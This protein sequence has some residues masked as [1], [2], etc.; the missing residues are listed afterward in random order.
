LVAAVRS[1]ALLTSADLYC[2]LSAL[3]ENLAVTGDSAVEFERLL[4]AGALD[5]VSHTLSRDEFLA[6]RQ[7]AYQH[8]AARYPRYFADPGQLAFGAFS[9]TRRKV[10]GTT[11]P[12]DSAL[13]LWSQDLHTQYRFEPTPLAVRRPVFEALRRREGQAITFAYFEPQLGDLARRPGAGHAIRRQISRA[14]TDDYLRMMDGDIVT[15]IRGL[16]IFDDLASRFPRYDLPVLGQIAYACGADTLVDVV[17]NSPDDMYPLYIARRQVPAARAAAAVRWLVDALYQL[18]LDSPPGRGADPQEWRSQANVRGRLRQQILG[19]TRVRGRSA[20]SAAGPAEIYGALEAAALSLAKGVAKAVPGVAPLLERTRG[21]LTPMNADVVLLTVNDIET[22]AVDGALTAGGWEPRLEYGD[23]NVYKIWEGAA[24]TVVATARSR[25]ST[26]GSGGATL[27][28]ID[29]VRELDPQA[30]I[31][32]GLAFGFDGAKTPIGTVLVSTRVVDYELQRVGTDDDGQ[33]RIVERGS[34]PDA[35]PRL[36]GLFR[37]TGLAQTGLPVAYGDI[38][39]GDKL[40]DNA[41]YRE[42][43]RN[44][45]PDA[46]GGEMEGAGILAAAEREQVMWLIVKGVCDLASSKALDEEVRQRMAAANSATA[47]LHVL[48]LGVFA[49]G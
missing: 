7:Q 18:D 9:A 26:R 35:H 3:W 22:A 31:A 36:L 8:D 12:L 11:A 45:F 33:M 38:V 15:G 41:A 10:S 21:T 43:L 30:V 4:Q 2:G 20:L 1:L 27:T 28:A 16:Y 34:R 17:L 42:E 6:S 32:V 40:I 48:Q 13:T 47:V 5:A 29:A 44:R 49:R 23:S 19:G 37:D 25:A 24:G 14:F 39:T 46:L